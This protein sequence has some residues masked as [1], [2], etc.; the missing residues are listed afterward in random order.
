MVTQ[1]PD[2]YQALKPRQ[3]AFCD[4][5]KALHPVTELTG[6]RHAG[7]QVLVCDYCV[8]PA[9]C[10]TCHTLV[11]LGCATIDHD[12]AVCCHWCKG[13]P[14]FNRVNPDAPNQG[15]W[16]HERGEYAPEPDFRAPRITWS[17]SP[18]AAAREAA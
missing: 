9:P 1:T 5:C 18:Y 17:A 4:G 10:G 6:F 14:G 15:F 2:L 16:S 3:T 11:P 8:K 7:Q 13:E 12:D